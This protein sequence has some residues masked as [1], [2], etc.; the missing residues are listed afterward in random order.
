MNLAGKAKGAQAPPNS[1]SILLA[2]RHH[3]VWPIQVISGRSAQT[4]SVHTGALERQLLDVLQQPRAPAAPSTA[5][6]PGQQPEGAGAGANAA[7]APSQATG[8]DQD[9][10]AGLRYCAQNV[11]S[12]IFLLA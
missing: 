6:E 1:P 12:N 10:P 4:A 3:Q 9:Q 2:Y 11:L 7:P 8:Q 5:V